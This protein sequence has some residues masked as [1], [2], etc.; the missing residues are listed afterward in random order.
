MIALR[1]ALGFVAGLAI[2]AAMLGAA[3]SIKINWEFAST[4]GRNSEWAFYLALAFASVE[5]T[6]LLMPFLRHGL[7]LSDL[8]KP[9]KAATFAFWIFTLISALSAAGF[10]AMNR[11][12]SNAQR[13]AQL[14]QTKSY[15]IELDNI[16]SRLSHSGSL[17]SVAEIDAEIK[18][19]PKGDPEK[20]KPRLE[21]E[22]AASIQ[23]DKDEKRLAELRSSAEWKTSIQ[24]AV[25]TTDAQ[26]EMFASALPFDK[27]ATEKWV[28][29]GVITLTII[30][31]E[32]LVGFTPY[33]AAMVLV[34]AIKPQ[35]HPFNGKTRNSRGITGVSEDG[36]L[37]LNGK[38][39]EEKA[40]ADIKA[41]LRV[42]REISG[43][44]QLANKWGWTFPYTERRLKEW[45]SM[46]VLRLERRPTGW[47]ITRVPSKLSV[48]QPVA[49][50]A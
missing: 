32:L 26:L 49:S 33:A 8:K 50:T 9:A 28:G 6:R 21:V 18:A 13:S 24:T 10:F 38:A 2:C 35:T 47:V 43:I 30:A 5:G 23:R 45:Q 3:M 39:T 31:L 1:I 27:E 25:A 41:Q 36:S 22:R 42:V 44:N 15:K 14:S 48:V 20:H 34:W 11:S 29:I 46:G 40:L 37:T 16:T 12:D 7:R 17:R 4:L 19:L